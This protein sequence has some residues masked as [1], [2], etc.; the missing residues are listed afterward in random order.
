MRGHLRRQNFG[1]FFEPRQGLG[2]G[3]DGRLGL[4]VVTDSEAGLP[5]K[6]LICPIVHRDNPG[7]RALVLFG[8]ERMG[9]QLE[10][11]LEILEGILEGGPAEGAPPARGRSEEQ[12]EEQGRREQYMEA[13]T[14]MDME[15]LPS[16]DFAFL[17]ELVNELDEYKEELP[18]HLKPKYGTLSRFVVNRRLRG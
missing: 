18:R 9:G 15:R 11:R 6:T 10:A 8:G 3:L 13:L 5:A 16:Q 14:K 7:M 1:E 12:S 4:L 17:A 2:L